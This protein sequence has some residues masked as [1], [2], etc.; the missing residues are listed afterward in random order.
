MVSASTPV[1]VASFP[2]VVAVGLDLADTS[3]PNAS[4]DSGAKITTCVDAGVVGTDIAEFFDELDCPRHALAQMVEGVGFVVFEKAPFAQMLVNP[5]F[6]LDGAEM[7]DELVVVS[8]V[9][10]GEFDRGASDHLGET[11]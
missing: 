8:P 2:E 4:A 3:T 5:K 1:T 7:L 6:V 11:Y 10:R 9:L